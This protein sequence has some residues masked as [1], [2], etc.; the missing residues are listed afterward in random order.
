MS[1]IHE[2]LRK[3]RR[4]AAHQDDLGV[5]FPG[6]LTGRRR[7]R[8][9]GTGM[10]LRITL[11]VIVGAIL[12]GVLWWALRATNSPTNASTHVIAP[13]ETHAPSIAATTNDEPA[14]PR[15][16][17]PAK[18]E[19]GSDQPP[20]DVGADSQTSIQPLPSPRGEATQHQPSSDIREQVEIAPEPPAPATRGESGERVFEVEA[21]LG[22][23]SLSLDYIV[24]RSTDPYVQING[25][26]VRV[27]G[28][29]EGFTVEEI[30]ESSVRLTDDR[31]PL[32][33]Q[34][35]ADIF[36]DSTAP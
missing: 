16:D 19:S 20:G 36:A 22:Y 13:T 17:A 26:D 33:L 15:D 4:E 23:A 21:D 3:A 5:V 34:V 32:V 27:G 11:T 14:A 30:T 1:L 28:H 9:L 24:F 7:Q 6:G 31:G 10:A 8:G 35:P 29:I 12:G 25:L 2:A 18:T